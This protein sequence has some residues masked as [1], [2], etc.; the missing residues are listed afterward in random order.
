MFNFNSKECCEGFHKYIF[1]IPI[2]LLLLVLIVF[3]GA[4]AKNEIRNE[5]KIIESQRTITVSADGKVFAKPDIG[6]ISLSVT[7]E[8]KT[9]SEAQK[10]STEAINK[11]MTFLKSAGIEDKDIKTTNYNIYPKYDYYKGKQV[12]IGYEVSQSLQIKIRNLEKSGNIIAGATDNGANIAGGLN[13]TIDDPDA[14]KA[15]AQKQAI[16]KARTKVKDLVFKLGVRL[17]E[18]INFSENGYIPPIY[19]AKSAEAL[20]IGGGSVSPEIPTGEN[21]ITSFVSLTYEIR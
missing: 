19:Y 20:G 8:A 14:L 10:K 1:K 21:E 2:I 18:L 6:Q 5:T 12:F 9:V 17:G 13:F 7:H 15:E 3:I 11:I 4:K 16:E